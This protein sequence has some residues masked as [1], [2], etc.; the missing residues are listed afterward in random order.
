MNY[1]LKFNKK[2]LDVYIIHLIIFLFIGLV[3]IFSTPYKDLFIGIKKIIT[4]RSILL[5]D[6]MYVSGIGAT[7][8]NASITSLLIL[9][10]YKINKT[11]P[12]GSM[13]MTL[14]LTLGFSMVGKNFINIWPTII[15]VYLY[16][17][18][19]KDS[20][21]NYVLIATLS[22]SLSP[23]SSELFEILNLNSY[24]TLL[25]SISISILI[26]MILPP[27]AKFTLKMHQGYNLYNVGFANGLITV[28]IIS[29]L[30]YFGIE[31]K[32]NLLW[33]TEYKTISLFL[34]ISLIIF[35]ISLGIKKF[36]L[37]KLSNILRHSGRTITDFYLMYGNSSYLNM[38]ILGIIFLS[39]IV[40]VNGDLNGP[41][42]AL[43]FC[44][45][46]F[47]AIGKHPLNTIPLVLGVSFTAYISNIQLNTPTTILT[48]LGSTALAPIS[49]QFGVII[50]FITGC[51]HL[52]LMKY[53]GHLSGGINLY[54]NGFIAGILAIILIPIIDG[55]KKGDI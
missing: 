44:I 34:V 15:G 17:K 27:L 22:T 37:S 40:I 42:I 26:G 36:H 10:I 53:I 29:I 45:I 23:I 28:L 48:S 20:F 31:I 4:T 33:S 14:W 41:T 47:G 32:Q 1:K 8:L 13:I 52:I 6:Y 11:K 30:N 55:F 16:S 9:M 43:L 7:L 39:Y 54:N 18:I 19:Q 2:C 38:G 12:N 3:G 51:L 25:L 46:G 5:T 35:L 50:G 49:G 21:S 24:I